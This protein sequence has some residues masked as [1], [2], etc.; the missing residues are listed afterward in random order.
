MIYN[1]FVTA[2]FFIKLN[3]INTSIEINIKMQF[4]ID[5]VK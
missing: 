5:F 4:K 1:D 3:V 2:S